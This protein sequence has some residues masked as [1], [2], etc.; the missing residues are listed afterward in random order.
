MLV[1]CEHNSFTLLTH[2]IFAIFIKGYNIL[3]AEVGS[4]VSSAGNTVAT[5]FFFLFFLQGHEDS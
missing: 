3:V 5:D 1:V 2:S 4:S